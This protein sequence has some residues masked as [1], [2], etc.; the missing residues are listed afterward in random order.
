MQVNSDKFQVIVVGKIKHSEHII[1]FTLNNNMH[2]EKEVKI[3]GV[4]I[5]FKVHS[6]TYARKHPNI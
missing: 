2:T 4:T 5:D 3:L 1:N 6:Q